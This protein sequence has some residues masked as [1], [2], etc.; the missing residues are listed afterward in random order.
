MTRPVIA[1][2]SHGS[3]S[4]GRGENGAQVGMNAIHGSSTIS[5]RRA[6]EPR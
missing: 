2:L 3:Y 4:V 1:V 6:M 5:V